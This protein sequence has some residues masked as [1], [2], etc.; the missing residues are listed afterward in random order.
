VGEEGEFSGVITLHEMKECDRSAL[1]SS[2]IADQKTIH[3]HP[4]IS[5][6]A[7]SRLMIEHDIQ[8]LPVV[9]ASDQQR[10]L[11]MLT[12]NDIA[13]QQNASEI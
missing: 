10:V 9:S 2:V 8:Q 3:V 13:R 4:E 5:I 1:L 12:H 6:R 7:A 11:G